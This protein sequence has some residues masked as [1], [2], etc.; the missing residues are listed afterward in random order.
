MQ[1]E[2]SLKDWGLLTILV[3]FWGSAFLMIAVAV[4][5]IPPLTLSA[6]RLSLATGVLFC[7]LKISGESLP[8]L[9]LQDAHVKKTN[10]VWLSLLGVGLV[11]N[12]LPFLLLAW[13]QTEIPSSI[14]SI[15]IGFSPLATLVLAHFLI[16]GEPITRPSA[17][18]FFLGFVG[19][20]V[21]MG[22]TAWAQFKLQDGALVLQI[23]IIIAALCMG[24][25]NVIAKRMA[26][27]APLGAATGLTLLAA[28]IITPIALIVDRPWTLS[29]SAPSLAMAALLGLLP[30]GLANV[31]F[32]V[33]IR[34]TGAVFLALVNYLTIPWA[35]LM[36]V[37]F[38]S[39][40]PGWNAAL[41]LAL[42]LGGVGI[43][44]SRARRAA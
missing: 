1:T 28:L 11:G 41:A 14:A 27:V 37:A 34:R 29:P 26:P 9:F 39:E 6:A 17:L 30:T 10:P 36:G 19:I 33:L 13:G 16:R 12:A 4:E 15:Y 44:Q 8:P 38:L 31:I 35:V 2:H 25:S 3:V 7:A 18:G 22:P 20:C 32:F 42:I 24:L 40:R 23:A 21:L 43:S 5:T